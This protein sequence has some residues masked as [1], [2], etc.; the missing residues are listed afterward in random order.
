MSC[1]LSRISLISAHIKQALPP[2]FATRREHDPHAKVRLFLPYTLWRWYVLEYDPAE[3]L[4]SG[5]AVESDRVLSYFSLPYLKRL[6]S[7]NYWM[8]GFKR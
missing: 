2:L 6:R 3:R 1:S 5:L 7:P 8:A 4:C